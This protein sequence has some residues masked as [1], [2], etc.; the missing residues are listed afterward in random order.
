VP[1]LGA[2]AYGKPQKFGSGNEV[3]VIIPTRNRR[4][5]LFRTLH[6]VLAQRAVS[7]SVV[8]VDDSGDDGTDK[9]LRSLSDPRVQVV[10][11]ETRRGVSEARNT[12]LALARTPWVAFVDDDDLWAPDKLRGQLAAVTAD[13]SAQWSCA[14]S[15]VVDDEARVRW[16]GD[17]LY[18]RD[19]S[20]LLLQSGS[21]P[22]GGSGVLAATHL[23]R[24]VGGF[25]VTMSNLADWDFYLRLAQKSPVAAVREPLVGYLLHPGSMAHDIR[26]SI[27]EYDYM[28]TK[29]APLRSARG[30]Q[31]DE[32][33]WLSYLAGMAYNGGHRLT[34]AQMNLRLAFRYARL[35]QLR[36]AGMAL[37]PTSVYRA[38]SRR[39]A[40]HVPEHWMKAAC[41]WLRPYTPPGSWQDA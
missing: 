1:D 36:S 24:A 19:L 25:D 3:T 23:A 2:D 10:R 6:S 12:G 41:D 4:H 15:V 28:T 29:Y 32:E 17:P 11:H 31:Q 22:G 35:R 39:G 7:Q 16:W 5:L 8:I 21:I 38:R 30:I 18:E 27:V 9:A 20:D 33:R 37:M 40:K 13:G 34:S 14:G 26:R